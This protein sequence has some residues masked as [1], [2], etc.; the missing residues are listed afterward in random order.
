MQ[1]VSVNGILEM[2]S[3]ESTV[4]DDL[5]PCCRMVGHDYLGLCRG[6]DY[7]AYFVRKGELL[8]DRPD[9]LEQD[10]AQARSNDWQARRSALVW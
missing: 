3:P 7:T 8:S 5:P 9:D 6:P 1:Q 2:R 10:N 4:E